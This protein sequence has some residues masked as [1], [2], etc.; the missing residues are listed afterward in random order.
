MGVKKQDCKCGAKGCGAMYCFRH[1]KV[2]GLRK[3]LCPCG[4]KECGIGLCFNINKDTGKAKTLCPCG[5]A[6][7]GGG[8]CANC[9]FR[10]L[11]RRADRQ[12]GEHSDWCYTCCLTKG[13]IK[14]NAVLSAAEITFL[15]LVETQIRRPLQ[16]NHMHLNRSTQVKP[17]GHRVDGYDKT[18][19]T[20]YEYDGA[21]WHWACLPSCECRH[22]PK[23]ADNAKDRTKRLNM[24]LRTKKRNVDLLKKGYN[25]WVCSSCEYRIWNRT[26]RPSPFPGHWVSKDT[27]YL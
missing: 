5:H 20:V 3:V 7:C 25:V 6:G 2:K 16:R 19:R 14:P 22:K 12:L 21:V 13:I 8:L 26:G 27:E 4:D 23:H 11:K 9:K 18:T 15:V 10:P 17:A 24:R 1:N